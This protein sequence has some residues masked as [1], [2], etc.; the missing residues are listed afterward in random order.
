M[1]EFIY[2]NP[3]QRKNSKKVGKGNNCGFDADSRAFIDEK[4]GKA[5]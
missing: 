4:Q 1:S 3:A 2:G 5:A